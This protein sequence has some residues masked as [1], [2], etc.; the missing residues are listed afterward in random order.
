MQQHMQSSLLMKMVVLRLHIFLMENIWSKKQR[1]Q[2]TIS[3]LQTFTISVTDDYTEY[4]D[5]E[6]IKIIN[7]NNRPFTSQVKLIK[8]DEETGKTVTFKWCKL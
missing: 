4:E 8:V 6:Q 3:L 2:R 7:I 1:L 5:I